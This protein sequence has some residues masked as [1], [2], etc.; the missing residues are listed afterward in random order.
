V[1]TGTKFWPLLVN[2]NAHNRVPNPNYE[3]LKTID[4]KSAFKTHVLNPFVFYEKK[5]T[6]TYANKVAKGEVEADV[7]VVDAN[8]SSD[9]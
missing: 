2:K 4:V 3:V 7:V 8:G 6:Q 1:Y 9:C 5:P